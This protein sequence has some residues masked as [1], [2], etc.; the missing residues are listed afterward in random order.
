M[1]NKYLLGMALLTGAFFISKILK[2]GG[3]EMD[4]I[5]ASLIV[6][7]Y[8]TFEQVPKVI[9]A[10]VKTVLEQLGFPELAE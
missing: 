6:S 10:R 2:K 3:E 9:Q 5:Y 8:K 1:K 7:G 4:V